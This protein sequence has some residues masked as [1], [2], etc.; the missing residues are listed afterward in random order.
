MRTFKKVMRES[1]VFDS[2]TCDLC[3]VNRGVANGV[4]MRKAFGELS[5]LA[6]DNDGDSESGMCRDICRECFKGKI[7]PALE[8][9]GLKIKQAEIVVP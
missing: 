6:V 9:I 4:E 5:Y 8:S 2:A 3:G 7:V 1:T